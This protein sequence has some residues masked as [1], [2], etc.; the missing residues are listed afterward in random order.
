[1]FGAILGAL[2]GNALG[3]GWATGRA[4]R[5]AEDFADQ[6]VFTCALRLV[7][8]TQRG[9]IGGDWRAGSGAVSGGHVL[10]EGHRFPVMSID[11]GTSRSPRFRESF[12]LPDGLRI[13]PAVGPSSRLEIATYPSLVGRLAE[14]LARDRPRGG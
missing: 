13:Y 1:M 3:M 7:E 6:G 4:R 10:I 2:I 8:G 9:L 12:A 14:A 11:L 5:A